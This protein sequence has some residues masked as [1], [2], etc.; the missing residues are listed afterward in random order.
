MQWMWWRIWNQEKHDQPHPCWAHRVSKCYC[1]VNHVCSGFSFMSISALYTLFSISMNINIYI[2]EREEI[3]SKQGSIPAGLM[4]T[5]VHPHISR[6]VTGCTDVPRN[7]EYSSHNFSRWLN[8]C[9]VYFLTC[10]T[11]IRTS[12]TFYW[13][14]SLSDKFIYLWAVPVRIMTNKWPWNLNCFQLNGIARA[15]GKISLGPLL[16]TTEF[17]NCSASDVSPWCLKKCYCWNWWLEFMGL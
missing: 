13:G 7:S 17:E 11:W 2:T 12:V 8:I 6:T 16:K 3:Q 14:Q 9:T 15:L 10:L 1:C 5:S 4:G